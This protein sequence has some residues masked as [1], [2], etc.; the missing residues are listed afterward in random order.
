MSVSAAELNP[1]P[2]RVSP[3]IKFSRWTF[4]TLGIFYG[5]YFQRKFTKIE[6]ARKEKEE[7]ERPEREARLA[8]ERKR[9]L[10]VEQAMLNE[11]LQL[12]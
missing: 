11:L 5:A 12:K 8:V 4:L 10:E 2:L 6:T 9:A 1:R 3:L 7:R